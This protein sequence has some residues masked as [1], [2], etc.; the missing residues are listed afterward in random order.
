MTP[1]EAATG[2]VQGLSSTEL[3]LEAWLPGAALNLGFLV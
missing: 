2:H 1:E 3:G